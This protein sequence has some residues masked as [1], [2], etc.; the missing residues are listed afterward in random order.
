M[1]RSVTYAFIL[2][3]LVTLLF[4]CT[5]G[6][7]EESEGDASGE[8]PCP[9]YTVNDDRNGDGFVDT[10]TYDC[11]DTLLYWEEHRYA[12][13]DL[14]ENLIGRR[15]R[16][17]DDSIQWTRLYSWDEND[18]RTLEAFYLPV[19]TDK[20]H[21]LAY[22]VRSSYDGEGNL[23]QNAE[24]DGD[25][26]LQW[27]E[28]YDYEVADVASHARFDGDAELEWVLT[29]EYDAE[30]NKTVQERYLPTPAGTG[31][32]T[33]AVQTGAL[34]TPAEDGH[35]AFDL[36]LPDPVA[37]YPDTAPLGDVP[38]GD[39]VQLQWTQRWWHR[40]GGSYSVRYEPFEVS[41]EEL[42]RPLI[43]TIDDENLHEAITIDVAY[44]D[45]GR[46]LSKVT[47]YGGTEVLDLSLTYTE[48]NEV[49][50]VESLTVT[51][52]GVLFPATYRV[53]YDDEDY[54]PSRVEI[55][56]P[57]GDLLQYFTYEYVAGGTTDAETSV[58]NGFDLINFGGRVD[59]ITQYDG[60][61]NELGRYTFTYDF[62]NGEIRID[63]E[64]YDSASDS[65][66]GSGYFLLTLDADGR[67]TEFA[68]YSTDGEEGD[69]TRIWYYHYA[70]DDMGYRV[71][72]SRFEVPSEA[73]SGDNVGEITVPAG[74]SWQNPQ[75]VLLL[76]LG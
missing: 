17:A 12:D 63:A 7:L 67:T 31:V 44:D 68:S 35:Y 46:P 65:Y 1:A 13:E 56:Q 47:T 55:R 45:G 26:A 58:G 59:T 41:G 62:D 52:A 71:D 60:D 16:G 28:A 19:S 53:E 11:N 23:T 64:A 43:L 75:D 2:A 33:A 50:L 74:F 29:Y 54:V 24:F 14:Q 4:G 15:R 70:Y 76:L 39:D 42:L 32:Q 25:G 38:S 27:Y 30:G 37:D 3:L 36:A 40:Q 48:H 66:T 9:N 51:G 18:E 5:L 61:E 10:L 8:P 20:D 49:T 22:Y 69:D 34:E 73:P 57:D 21:E 72:E 6:F